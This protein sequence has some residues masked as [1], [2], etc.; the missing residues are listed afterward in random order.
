[1]TTLAPPPA[2]T[3]YAN[4]V[5]RHLSGLDAETLDELTGGLEA[6]LA[7]ALAERAPDGDAPDLAAVT[8]VFGSPAD[9]AEELRVAA[10]VE[11]PDSPDSRRPPLR[12][13]IARQVAALREDWVEWRTD[14]RW[15]DESA[16]FLV[17]LRPV[18]WVL[19]GWVL[20]HF[21]TIAQQPTFGEGLS[22]V[23]LVGLVI[24]SV[25]WGQGRVGQQRWWRRLGLV[26]GV[27]AILA[28]LPVAS[29]LHARMTWQSPTSGMGYSEGYDDGYGVGMY[30]GRAQAMAGTGS[31]S[32]ESIAG[33][34]NLFVYGPDGEPIPSARIVDQNGDAV[35][36]NEPMTGTPWSAWSPDL[37]WDEGGVP[38]AVL[39]GADTPLNLYPYSYMANGSFGEYVDDNGAPQILGNPEV[40][41]APTWPVESL[42]PLQDDPATGTLDVNPATEDSS[43]PP[44]DDPK[45]EEE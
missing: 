5:R 31:E 35:V 2:V 32:S 37:G 27:V 10:G 33:P 30:E 26:L 43:A 42:D 23:F 1:M 20:F 19:R 44:S 41:E 36:L 40:A 13:L 39:Q 4:A 34:V 12:T 8:A 24:L 7:E 6:D 28:L 15:V 45:A 29:V 3:E 11:L 38:A 18:W 17:A 22:R 16:R 25:L 9:Y 14:Q 21:V